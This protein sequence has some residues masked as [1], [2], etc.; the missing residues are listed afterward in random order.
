MFF[1]PN[2]I[3]FKTGQ[4]YQF[5]LKNVDK[6]KHEVEVQDK[7]GDLL[8]EIKGAVREVEVGPMQEVEWYIVPIQPGKNIA[9]VCAIAGHKEVGM[10]GLITIESSRLPK[11]Y[12]IFTPFRVGGKPQY[13][14]GV[15]NRTTRAKF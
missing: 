6:I 14:A 8:A 15:V 1:N 3:N 7:N 4:A 13:R 10:H 2:H 11:S 9:M 12:S 5:V